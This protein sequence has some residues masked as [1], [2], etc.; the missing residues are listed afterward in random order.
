MTDLKVSTDLLTSVQMLS[1]ES[2]GQ[3]LTE[4]LIESMAEFSSPIMDFFGITHFQ[5]IVFAH[6]IEAEL[7][8]LIV[9]NERITDTFGKKLSALASVNLA[10]DELLAK[11]LIYHKRSEYGMRRKNDRNK[12]IAVHDKMLDALMTGDAS[13]LTTTQTEDFQALL[14]EVRELIVKRMEK[15]IST[16]ELVDQTMQILT[17]N[18]ALPEVKWLLKIEGIDKYDMVLL[19]NLTIET[20]EDGDRGESD[21]SK[22]V[23]EVFSEI[24]DRV[25]YKRNIKEN[26]CPLYTLKLVE[27]SDNDFSFMD[28]TRLSEESME[29]LLGG[30]V[31]VTKKAIKPKFGTLIAP[32]KIVEEELFYNEAE[33]KQIDTLVKALQKD[34]YDLIVEKLKSKGSIPNFIGIMAGLPGVGKTASCYQIAKR[35]NRYVYFIDLEKISS[36]WVG[37]SSLN[38]VALF[39]EIKAINASLDTPAVCIFNEAEQVVYR[40]NNSDSSVSSEKNGVI[41]QFLQQFEIFSGIAFLTTNL[42]DNIDPGF[43]RRILFK[44]SIKTPAPDVRKKILTKVFDDINQETIERINSKYELTG[45]QIGN[46]SKKLTVSTLLDDT[47]NKDEYIMELCEEEL[48]FSKSN[49]KPIGF[50]Q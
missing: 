48:V 37:Q 5:S 6:L 8:S 1:S 47:I 25:R 42:I 2:K 29:M 24:R 15:I 18:N 17:S 30:A 49:R 7:R 43:M 3:A 33:Q 46:V 34:N 19:L 36:K 21:M 50:V 41:A 9:D 26:K 39:D 32:D 40:R 35:T 12:I 11:K 44:L 45:A 14:A 22:L 27:F 16:D 10:L 13:L 4:E 28:Y 38:C 23:N 31:E 20:F